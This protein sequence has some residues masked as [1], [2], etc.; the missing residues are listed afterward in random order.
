MSEDKAKS[1]PAT[2]LKST[3]GQAVTFP[4]TLELDRLDGERVQITFQCK[5]KGKRAWSKERR[6]YLDALRAIDAAADAAADV[7]DESA[8]AR[9]PQRR[10]PLDELVAEGIERDAEMVAKV[11]TGWSLPEECNADSLADLDDNFGGALRKFLDKYERA[12][13]AGQLGN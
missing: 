8:E 9:P 3:N 6:E 2:E 1:K 13:Y 5:F 11:V 7:V 12:V 10:R 4:V